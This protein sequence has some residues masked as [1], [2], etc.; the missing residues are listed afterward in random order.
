MILKFGSWKK[1]NDIFEAVKNGIKT[2]ET[3]PATEKYLGIGVGDRL[4]LVSLETSET[5]E[6][7]VSYVHKY[8][9]VEEM[10]ENEEVSK[11]VPGVKTKEELVEVFEE[12]KKKWGKEYAEKLEKFGIVAVGLK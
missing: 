2:I 7:K 5:C 10:G 9:T 11:I 4:T 12:F 8:K 3:R 1:E 6:R